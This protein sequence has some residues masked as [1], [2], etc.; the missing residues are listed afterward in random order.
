MIKCHSKPTPQGQTPGIVLDQRIRHSRRKRQPYSLCRHLGRELSAPSC[1]ASGDSWPHPTMA[2][3][4][5]LLGPLCMLVPNSSVF[6]KIP[7]FRYLPF[8]QPP[9]TLHCWE[10][11]RT[12]LSRCQNKEFHQIKSWWH[13]VC[14][15]NLWELEHWNTT[16]IA[17]L[18]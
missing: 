9:D 13:K 6:G 11:Q 2:L 18:L 15:Y 5:R 14:Y 12:P 10:A 4:S 1:Q 3:L 17:G 7:F 8:F 16:A